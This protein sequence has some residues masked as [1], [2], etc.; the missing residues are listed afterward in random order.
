MILDAG[1][2][3][4]GE[5]PRPADRH[6]EAELLEE[7]EEHIGADP[8]RLLVRANEVLARDAA[9]MHLHLLVLEQLFHQ[10]EGGYLPIARMI[11]RPSALWSIIAACAPTG[12]GGV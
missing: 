3:R 5:A 4:I 10:V 1:D 2:Q 12:I 7:A 9:E 8:G 6:A 11:S